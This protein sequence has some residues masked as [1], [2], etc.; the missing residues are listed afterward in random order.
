MQIVEQGR[1]IVS[2]DGVLIALL[3][4]TSDAQGFDNNQ[5]IIEH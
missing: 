1:K 3:P 2:H 4:G 5:A